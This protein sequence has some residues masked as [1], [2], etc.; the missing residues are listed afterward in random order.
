MRLNILTIYLK[1]MKEVLRDRKTLV[2]MLVMP[3]VVVPL[4]MNL[5][6]GFVMKADEKARTEILPFAV[7]GAENLPDLAGEFTEEMGFRKVDIPTMEEIASAIEQ[8]KIK[9]EHQRTIETKIP[10]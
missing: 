4:L 1:E 10:R 9:F 6:I 5:L 8:N 7:F 3:I 2:F